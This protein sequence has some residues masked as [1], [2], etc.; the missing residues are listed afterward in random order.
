MPNLAPTAYVKVSQGEHGQTEHAAPHH[1]PAPL[2]R[3]TAAM[4]PSNTQCTSATEDLSPGRF[5]STP[6]GPST[7]LYRAQSAAT[8][9]PRVHVNFM[10]QLLQSQTPDSPL[11][12]KPPVFLKVPTPK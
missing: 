6:L 5:Q 1:S 8:I 11:E 4:E 7:P 9:A 2:P 10:S 3:T 12:R